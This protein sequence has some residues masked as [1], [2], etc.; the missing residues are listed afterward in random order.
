MKTLSIIAESGLL[1]TL[2][3]VT[4]GKDKNFQEQLIW[5]FHTAG[6]DRID[7]RKRTII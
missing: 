5:L 6:S 1:I 4:N 7:M 2:K 3:R